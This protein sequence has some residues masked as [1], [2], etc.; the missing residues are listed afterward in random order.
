M[1]WLFAKLY[2]KVKV[3]TNEVDGVGK[4][5]THRKKVGNDGPEYS[6][7][8]DLLKTSKHPDVKVF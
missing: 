2:P 6:S 8:K 4:W 1:I 5:G 3:L 7:Q